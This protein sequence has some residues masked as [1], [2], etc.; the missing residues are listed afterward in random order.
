MKRSTF[1]T[2]EQLKVGSLILVAL[3]IMIVAIFRLGQAANLFTERYELVTFLPNANGLREG[4]SVT[5]AGQLAGIVKRIDFL[6]VDG[7]TTRNLRVTIAVDQS[8]QEQI[9]EDTR[10]KLRT[11]GLLGDKILDLS[12]GTPR[13]A[14]LQPGDTVPATE[15]LDY[16]AVIAQASGAVGDMV[17]LTRD[18]RSIT[19]GM[20]RGEGTMGQLL[21]NRTLYDQLSTT[22]VQTNQLLARMQQP[23]GTLGRMLDDPALY[24]EMVAVTG[25]LDSLLH[26]I[27]S[28]Q[29][30]LGQLLTDTTLYARLVTT[31]RSADSLLT[32]LT[33]G[34]GFA[35]RLLTDQQLYDNLNKAITDLNAILQDVRRDPRKYTKGMV[36]IF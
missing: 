29:G 32:M 27:N 21:T 26:A 13:F 11:M 16:E 15:S 36:R 7:D 4:G 35:A 6:P 19:G 1:I 33:Q 5:V 25:S 12:V 24:N 9:R 34:N 28:R 20:V 23:H 2:W 18:L 22:L 30:T 3:L 14:V 17:E 31:T 10:A 8:L